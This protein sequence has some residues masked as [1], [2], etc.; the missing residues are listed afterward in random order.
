M[1]PRTMSVTNDGSNR[2]SDAPSAVVNL[3]Q[4][5][6]AFFEPTPTIPA[7]IANDATLITTL[8]SRTL[9]SLQSRTQIA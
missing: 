3:F 1:D 9:L 8:Q 6:L 2:T 5:I 7:A 4:V